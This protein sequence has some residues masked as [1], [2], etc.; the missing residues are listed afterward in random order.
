MATPGGRH[1][2]DDARRLEPR[3]VAEELEGLPRREAQRV[4]DLLRVDHRLQ[5]GAGLRGALHGQEEGEQAI[6]LRLPG[7]LAQGLAEREVR[8]PAVGGEARR[9]S[10]GARAAAERSV[11][12]AA[13]S[14]ARTRRFYAQARRQPP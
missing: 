1:A 5:P 8:S 14:L 4:E 10:A 9:V 7:V 6:A 12:S 3:D 2:Q 13:G 11:T